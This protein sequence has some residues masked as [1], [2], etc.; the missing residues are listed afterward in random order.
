MN[1]NTKRGQL[2]QVCFV[3]GPMILNYKILSILYDSLMKDI[4]NPFLSFLTGK[5]DVWI[6]VFIALPKVFGN[7]NTYFQ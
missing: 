2:L 7:G 4:K 3:M 6:S 1:V 5:L